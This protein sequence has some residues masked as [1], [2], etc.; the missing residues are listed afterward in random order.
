MHPLVRSGLNPASEWLEA[1]HKN[2][3]GEIILRAPVS[4]SILNVQPLLRR[5]GP[6]FL[7]LIESFVVM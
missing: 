1:F 2:P 7:F 4:P 5:L 6:Q 3:F